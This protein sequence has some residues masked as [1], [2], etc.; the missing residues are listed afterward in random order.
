M[1]QLLLTVKCLRKICILT[2]TNVSLPEYDQ[3]GT[4]H[5]EFH[6]KKV[7]HACC[8]SHFSSTF[9]AALRLGLNFL[10][11]PNKTRDPSA[12]ALQVAVVNYHR[13]IPD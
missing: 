13:Y 6:N 7:T 12:S 11:S 2:Y 4:S 10:C 5:F 8:Y 3:I 9:E 1:H